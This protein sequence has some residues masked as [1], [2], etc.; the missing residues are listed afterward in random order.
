MG[1]DGPHAFEFLNTPGNR[2]SAGLERE[3]L[4]GTSTE[5]HTRTGSAAGFR[6]RSA[7]LDAGK[8]AGDLAGHLRHAVAIGRTRTASDRASHCP[9]R[10]ESSAHNGGSL[11]PRRHRSGPDRLGAWLTHWQHGNRRSQLTA[12][13]AP[14]AEIGR[15]SERHDAFSA[16]PR[17]WRHPRG[18]ISIHDSIIKP[19]AVSPHSWQHRRSFRRGTAS[20]G[21][22]PV[23]PRSAG[24]NRAARQPLDCHLHVVG[25][26]PPQF[27]PLRAPDPDVCSCYVERRVT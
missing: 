6:L 21:K 16:R 18:S 15:G 19:H 17:S 27:R 11:S 4:P 10:P 7:L 1:A 9:A 12:V 2:P 20:S 14:S 23:A 5:T 26:E 13:V 8:F 3:P 24:R 25:I 22:R